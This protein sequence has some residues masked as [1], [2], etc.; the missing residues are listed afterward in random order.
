V[1]SLPQLSPADVP[2]TLV[3]P[4]GQVTLLALQSMA[5]AETSKPLALFGLPTI[6]GAYWPQQFDALLGPAGHQQFRGKLLTE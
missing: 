5:K 4:C 1:V 3:W 2:S 6:I